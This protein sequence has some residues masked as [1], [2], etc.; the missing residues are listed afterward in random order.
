MEKKQI[1]LQNLKKKCSK[2][3]SM[4]SINEETC[5]ICKT[6]FRKE[7][8]ETKKLQKKCQHCLCMVNLDEKVCPYCKT[9]FKELKYDTIASKPFAPPSLGV[10]A[11]KIERK[12]TFFIKKD[13]IQEDIITLPQ[14]EIIAK[15]IEKPE[16]PEIKLPIIKIIE[17]EKPK[18]DRTS[19]IKKIVK[20]PQKAI[21]DLM[22][23]RIKNQI[24]KLNSELPFIY[25][26]KTEV[27]E[28]AELLENDNII[29]EK[30][31][32]ISVSIPIEKKE[33]K[34][35][36]SEKIN[37]LD[38]SQIVD[39]IDLDTSTKSPEILDQE[40]NPN[41]ELQSLKLDIGENLQTLDLSSFI[42][43]ENTSNMPKLEIV[44]TNLIINSETDEQKNIEEEKNITEENS[45]VKLSQSELFK[46]S[47]LDDAS[48]KENL[49]KSENQNKDIPQNLNN[50]FVYESKLRGSVNFVARNLYKDAK[51]FYE[52]SKE[53]ECIDRL[54]MALD[55]DPD[56]EQ[57]YMLLGKTYLKLRKRITKQ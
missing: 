55:A 10:Q 44:E 12:D 47:D 49:N 37:S 15:I 20:A 9:P 35:E 51:I 31:F 43:S 22:K 18:T 33:I 46:P 38:F 19:M 11:E 26:N 5:P 6:P 30:V 48:K 27:F 39:N 41:L 54:I 21:E 23:I 52:K 24:E 32:E 17:H 53:K 2:C 40:E 3:L 56:F 25:K 13:K 8:R 14:K 1:E 50:I 28:I 45:L 57:A 34:E 7:T 29:E 36:Q 4:V 16:K 42:Q